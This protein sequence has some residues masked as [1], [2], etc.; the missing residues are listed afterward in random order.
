MTSKN[1]VNNKKVI[2]SGGKRKRTGPTSRSFDY[3]FDPSDGYREELFLD[4]NQSDVQLICVGT[5][6]IPF[7]TALRQ[8]LVLSAVP[9]FP[10]KPADA[11]LWRG[12]RSWTA[13]L[14]GKE[15]GPAQ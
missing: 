6:F 13:L 14:R 8:L 1:C 9:P 2:N 5:S 4:R 11:G 15:K 10:T 7:A 3:V 12:P